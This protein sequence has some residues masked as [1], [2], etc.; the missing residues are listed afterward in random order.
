MGEVLGMEPKEVVKAEAQQMA[1]DIK[2]RVDQILAQFLEISPDNP[3][4]DI[5]QKR[6]VARLRRIL[7]DVN[8]EVTWHNDWDGAEI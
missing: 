3:M 5:A 1:G 4:Y 7:K 2:K 8:E 6:T